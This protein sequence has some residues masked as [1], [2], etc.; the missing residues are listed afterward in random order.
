MLELGNL[1]AASQLMDSFDLRDK[2]P[3]L[4]PRD[5]EASARKRAEAFL[6]LSVDSSKVVLVNNL[7]GVRQAREALKAPPEVRG[8][9]EG[10]YSEGREGGRAGVKC[11]G[12]DVENSPTSGRATLLQVSNSTGV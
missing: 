3:P 1:P 8:G 11:V 5:V 2:F 10:S 4:D 12:L 7:E 6:Q 9:G